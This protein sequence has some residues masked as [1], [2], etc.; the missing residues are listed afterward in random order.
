MNWPV[1]VGKRRRQPAKGT[2]HDWKQ[3]IA[4]DCTGQCIYCAISEARFGG[5]RNFHVE[6][7]RPKIRFPKLENTIGNLYLACAICNVLKSDDW[8]CE[9]AANH[10]RAAYPDP[11]KADFNM[12]F[13]VSPRTHAVSSA[14]IAGRYLIERVVLNRVQLILERRLHAM[15]RFSFDFD[16]WL[17]Q[18]INIMTPAELKAAVNVLQAVSRVQIGALTARPYKNADTKR[19]VSRRR[20]N[21]LGYD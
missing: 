15:L 18:S 5:I 3:H 1:L 12:L 6:H 16:T 7:F 9:P 20:R 19:K 17:N 10:S 13:V 4:N 2:W 11:S 8:P 14:V 21:T